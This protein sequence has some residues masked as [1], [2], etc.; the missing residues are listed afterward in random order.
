MARSN[1]FRNKTFG[2]P[3]VFNAVLNKELPTGQW[4]TYKRS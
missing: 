1:Y 4:K 3:R 2:A